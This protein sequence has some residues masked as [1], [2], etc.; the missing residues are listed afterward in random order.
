MTETKVTN[1]NL[2]RLFREKIREIRNDK[3]LATL[4]VSFLILGSWAVFLRMTDS[5]PKVS[6]PIKMSSIDENIPPGYTLLPIEIENAEAISGIISDMGG[7]VDLYTSNHEGGRSFRVATKVK[8]IRTGSEFQMSLLIPVDQ[9]HVILNHRGPFI[10]SVHN[11][12]T[13]TGGIESQK[14][15]GNHVKTEIIFGNQD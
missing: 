13:K 1:G 11:L 2:V 3:K 15:E 9:G 8:L 10:A 6:G 12:H 14:K 4:W 5:K 7:L